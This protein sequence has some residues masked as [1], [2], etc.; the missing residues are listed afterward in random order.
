MHVLLIGHALSP[1]HGSEYGVTWNWAQGLAQ[2]V[3]VTVLSYPRYRDQVEATLA[4]KP[5]PRLRVLWLRPP[6]IGLP[7]R[8]EAHESR[9]RYVLW[10]R[11]VAR[12]AQALDFDLVH[13]V[14]WS[15]VSVAPPFECLGKP[16][17]WG[18]CGGGQ[19][20]PAGFRRYFGRAW[21]REWMRN[22]RVDLLPS[23]PGWRRAVRRA[24]LLL[25]TNRETQ[26]LLRRSSGRDVPLFLD[27][28]VPTTFCPSGPPDREPGRPFRLLWVGRLEPRKAFP[29][30][31]DALAQVTEPW[32]LTVVGQGPLR[33]TWEA[34]ATRFGA[35]VRFLGQVDWPAMPRLFRAADALLFTSLR[36]SFG[37]VVLEALAHGVPVIGL[38]HQGV[39]TFVPPEAA[40]K[41]P[42]TCPAETV[43]GLAAGIGRLI[44]RPEVWH[45]MRQAA[46][47]YAQTERWERR[48][49][50]MLGLYESVLAG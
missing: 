28:G 3:Q 33:R 17:I 37:S 23:L 19:K 36:D 43:R 44:R 26:A 47:R 41:V 10:L 7:G 6:S 29:L 45:R 21:I 40:I 35:S 46:W 2:H 24:S 49:E 25:A 11:Q 39:G 38:D 31:L 50:R 42:V 30:A 4:R 14:S 8:S 20:A 22:L 18:P 15:T 12:A 32:E 9:L 1:C 27:S 16:G 48:V 34:E 5:Q 13:Y